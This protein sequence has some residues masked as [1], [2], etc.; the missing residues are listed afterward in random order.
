MDLEDLQ[1]A[2][3]PP[4]GL[5]DL[6]WIWRTPSQGLEDIY[7]AGGPLTALEVLQHP[8]NNALLSLSPH[9]VCQAPV[10]PPVAPEVQVL[11]AS[12]CTPSR[13]LWGRRASNWHLWV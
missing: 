10:S 5:E 11:H 7:G 8:S 1:R 12:S 3:G 2:G 6:Q 9:T 13:V 4:M